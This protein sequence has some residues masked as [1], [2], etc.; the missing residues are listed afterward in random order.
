MLLIIAVCLN[1][2]SSKLLIF[3][4]GINKKHNFWKISH[5]SWFGTNDKKTYYWKTYYWKKTNHKL[6]IINTAF[7]RGFT[8]MLNFAVSYHSWFGTNDKKTYYWK[9]YYWK[10]T[11]HKLWI[12]NTAFIRGFTCMLNFAVSW[13]QCP[14]N[15]IN[16]NNCVNFKKFRSQCVSLTEKVFHRN[17]IIN[18]MIPKFNHFAWK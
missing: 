3:Q 10:K 14:H 16:N 2:T 11:N 18:Q 7:I 15:D 8:C 4:I 12:I 6:W 5:H 1:Y 9:T 17:D 13:I